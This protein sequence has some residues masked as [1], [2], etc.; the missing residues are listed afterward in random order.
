MIRSKFDIQKKHV[1]DFIEGTFIKHRDEHGHGMITL[2]LDYF[3]SILEESERFRKQAYQR[4][5]KR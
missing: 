5:K 3:M 1:K 2:E 4:G